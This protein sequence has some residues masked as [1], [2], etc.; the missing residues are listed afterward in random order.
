MAN[1]LS[2]DASI[3]DRLRDSVG[4][5]IKGFGDDL[6]IKR[7]RA[8]TTAVSGSGTSALASVTL[9]GTLIAGTATSGV[10][11]GASDFSDKQTIAPLLATSRGARVARD[12]FFLGG[13]LR[14]LDGRAPDVRS[15]FVTGGLAYDQPVKLL[16]TD[17]NFKTNTPVALSPILSDTSGNLKS[18]EWHSGSVTTAAAGRDVTEVHINELSYVPR[19]CGGNG[20]YSSTVVNITS[21]DILQAKESLAQT[22]VLFH[23]FNG[24]VNMYGE[25]PYIACDVHFSGASDGN[26]PNGREFRLMAIGVGGE[27][28]IVD[29]AYSTVTTGFD[30]VRLSGVPSLSLGPICTVVVNSL[31]AVTR[32]SARIMVTCDSSMFRIPRR[33]I[34]LDGYTDQKP[35]T[36]E[37]EDFYLGWD[38]GTS[39]LP[40][41]NG[42]VTLEYLL[43]GKEPP[44]VRKVEQPRPIES[45]QYYD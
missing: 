19:M 31:S 17:N 30:S 32:Q 7:I 22:P 28:E 5:K 33:H 15:G 26:F 45:A 8:H 23:D 16:T 13:I 24:S 10:Y 29:T 35:V 41:N 38:E 44:P 43:T 37:I 18:K 42:E 9:G 39:N 11:V 21:T 4:F 3:T 27:V 14:L 1:I 6:I 34:I 12:D 2:G 36:F 25:S 40:K 20:R